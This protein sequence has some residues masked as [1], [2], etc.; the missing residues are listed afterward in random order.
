MS[1]AIKEMQMQDLRGT[2]AANQQSLEHVGRQI[3]ALATA[4]NAS[5]TTAMSVSQ[6]STAAFDAAKATQAAQVLEFE[7]LVRVGRIGNQAATLAVG[8]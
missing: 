7:W 8:Q 4:K 1:K 2:F 6:L 3:A 5:V